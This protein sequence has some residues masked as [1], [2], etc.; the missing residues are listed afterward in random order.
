MVIETNLHLGVGIVQGNA[1]SLRRYLTGIPTST[2]VSSAKLTV[3]NS[4]ADPDS[5]AIYQLTATIEDAGSSG[6]ATIRFDF[7]AAN[8]NAMTADVE[9]YWDWRATLSSGSILT[10]ESGLTSA[11]AS[12]TD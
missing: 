1:F 5:A 11:K 2:T 10:I 12:V 8:T 6:T 3:K 4:P 7:T 9:Y